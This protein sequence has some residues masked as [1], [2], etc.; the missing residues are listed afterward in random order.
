MI[1]SRLLTYSMNAVVSCSI[2]LTGCAN[3]IPSNDYIPDSQ[4]QEEV[5]Q[6]SQNNND[7]KTMQ[8]GSIFFNDQE[9]ILSP[10]SSYSLD[11]YSLTT[12]ETEI[13]INSMDIDFDI[14]PANLAFIDDNGLLSISNEANIGNQIDVSAVYEGFTAHL[15]ITVKYS[16][17]DTIVASNDGIP[18]VT[19]QESTAVLV[20]KQRSLQENYVPNDLVQPNIPFSFAG[21]S[22]KKW[23]RQE[24]ATALE[25]LFAK[26]E[27][28]QIELNAVSGYRSYLTQQSIFNWNVQEQGEEQ[29][30]RYSAYPGTSEHQTGLAMDVSSPSVNN[31]LHESLGD[32]KEGQWLAEHAAE[33]GFII[34]YP[35]DKEHITGY[36]YEPWHLRYVGKEIA[37]DIMEQGITLEEYFNDAIP[38]NNP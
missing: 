9:M 33:F 12:D 15:T 34:R 6:P 17:E 24:A 26:A 21:E 25:Q 5:D 11:L 7:K 30:R 31:A 32:T 37:A 2:L 19:N 14:Q 13:E 29:A 36:A 35:Q 1:N 10:G 38:V 18:Q 28:N 8:V 4:A 27:Q 3:T 23:L 20:N 22:E 16:I